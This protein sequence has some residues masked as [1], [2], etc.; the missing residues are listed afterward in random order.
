[1][2]DR[3][4]DN[5]LAEV[6]QR[7]QG[8]LQG[9]VALGG[10]IND[11]LEM[12]RGRALA[13]IH[14]SPGF[15]GVD[16]NTAHEAARF[17]VDDLFQLGPI[18]ELLWDHEVSEIMVNS[19]DQIMIERRGHIE[20]APV[21]FFDEEHVQRTI[22]RIVT[23]DN[24][25]CDQ[26]SP[27]CD[28]MLHRAGAPFDGSRVNAVAMGIAKHWTLDIRKFRDDALTPEAL[29]E[30][31]SMDENMADFLQS[32][33]LARM[34]IVIEGGTGSGKTTL[35][36]AL[37]NFIPDDQRIITVEDTAELNL[38]KTHVVSLQ[39]RPANNEGKGQITLQQLVINTLR[40]RPDRIVVGECRGAEAFDMLQAMN[41]G[42]DGSLTTTHANNPRSA[43]D[44]MQSMVQMNPACASMPP[45]AIMKI[46]TEAVDFIVEIKRMP[47][48]SRR[49]NDI[50]E[51]CGSQGGVPTIGSIIKF[52]KTGVDDETGR[53]L[54]KFRPTGS[55]I[56][57]ENHK[58]RFYA[59]GV[60]IKTS[61]F[62]NGELW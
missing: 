43:I 33:V 6:M 20:P 36:N 29:I 57:S 15:E 2:L 21:H 11:S 41:S 24:R 22:T 46:I 56:V 27:L 62:D 55:R 26:Q 8:D 34:N 47:D 59:N 28:C 39:A 44:R 4:Y 23:A 53:I 5:A 9:Q 50:S 13:Y 45:D 35:L 52:A 12:L 1:M 60:E 58:E 31:G 54:G 61:W 49:I 32:L 38:A 30:N 51:V 25:R 16:E 37:S 14:R 19:P 18:E 3:E 40:E 7:C 17:V 48:G 10:D 42:H